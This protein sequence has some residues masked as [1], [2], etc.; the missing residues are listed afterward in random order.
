MSAS[1]RLAAASAVA[2]SLFVFALPA[3]AADL[4]EDGY[5]EGPPRYERYAPADFEP[6]YPPRYAERDD[7]VP[8]NGS[9]R[10]AGHS[11]T[12]RGALVRSPRRV[13]SHDRSVSGDGRV[14]GSGPCHGAGYG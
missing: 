3:A 4:Y 7:C 10:R 13:R 1:A 8:R 14:A 6:P 11:V 9:W 5:G 12:R 2:A